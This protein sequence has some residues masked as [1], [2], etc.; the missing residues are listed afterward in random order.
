MLVVNRYW[1]AVGGR[2]NLPAKGTAVGPLVG[3]PGRIGRQGHR[4]LKRD[5]HVDVLAKVKGWK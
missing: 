3:L 5:D 2:V 4:H 1:S